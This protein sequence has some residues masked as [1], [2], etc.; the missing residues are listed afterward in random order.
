MLHRQKA[1]KILVEHISHMQEPIFIVSDASLNA[2]KCS[3][4]SWTI[5][6][7]HSELW[8]GLGTCPGTQCDTHSGHSEGYS[9]LAA[10]S[11]LEKY[12]VATNP[13]MPITPISIQGFCDN[14]GLIQQVQALQENRLPNPSQALT[15]DHNLT[16][17]IYQTIKRLPVPITLKHIKGHQ[18]KDSSPEDLSYKAQLN[19]VCDDRARETLETLPLNLRP[20]PTLPA[21]YPHLQIRDQ[22]IV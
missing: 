9:L 8:T 10:M 3:A 20:N 15:N 11:F 17:K 1:P 13:M 19:I 14:A 12:I 2:Q 5:S 22:T 7:P 16:N 18:D 21:T 4:F 6:T